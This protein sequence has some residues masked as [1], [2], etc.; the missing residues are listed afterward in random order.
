MLPNQPSASSPFSEHHKIETPE[1]TSLQFSIA[2]IGT[3]FLALAVDLMIEAA[4]GA[5]LLVIALVL[6]ITGVLSNLPFSGQWLAGLM[7]GMFFLLQ[8]GYFAV[9]E[10]FWN[11][12]TPGKR[13]VHIRVVKDSG[14]PLSV[15]ETIG[16]N[17]MRIVD[18]LPAFYAVGIVS[19][20]LTGANK[21]LGDLVT[22]AIVIR[23]GSLAT[24]RPVWDSQPAVR[25]VTA[26]GSPQLSADDL[27]LIDAFL[28]RRYELPDHVRSRVAGEILERLRPRILIQAD[29]ETSAES[30]LESLAHERRSTGGYG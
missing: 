7:I 1:Q 4:A 14:R 13:M 30:V 28:G 15:S 3:R 2:G 27:A 12:Q 10:I 17:L 5:V 11:G 23:E 20:L 18:Q 9:F 6:G 16:R 26:A 8:F 24:L 21:R 25:A 22:G 19:M 29:R